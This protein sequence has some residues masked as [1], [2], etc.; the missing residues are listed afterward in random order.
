[1]KGLPFYINTI[2][3]I[4]SRC[5]GNPAISNLV[6]RYPVIPSGSYMCVILFCVLLFSLRRDDLREIFHAS[7][8]LT[9]SRFFSPMVCLTNGLQIF[10]ADFVQCKHQLL[11][12][13]NCRIIKYFMKVSCHCNCIQY[14]ELSLIRT[15]ELWPSMYSSHFKN[16][17]WSPT[18]LVPRVARS[19]S[20]LF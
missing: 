20:S 17:M 14:S 7:R 4:V 6:H 18:I 2:S 16:F 19:G 3:S 8:W 5:I 1:M 9:D 15:N 12:V 11:G 13:V 10:V